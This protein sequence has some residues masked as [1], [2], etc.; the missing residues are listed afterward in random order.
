MGMEDGRRVSEDGENTAGIPANSPIRHRIS[1]I[2]GA[3]SD[4]Y[5]F[6]PGLIVWDTLPEEIF[7]ERLMETHEHPVIN[8]IYG[9][10]SI[11]NFEDAPVSRDLILEA[12]KAA[13]WAPSGLNNQPWRFALAWEQKKEELILLER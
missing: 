13:S 5:L 2:R 11:R 7:G 4:N 6:C 8:A 1:N 9:R 3:G 10:R 12:V